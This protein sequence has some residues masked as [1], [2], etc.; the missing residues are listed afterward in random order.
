MAAFSEEV[1]QINGFNM[2]YKQIIWDFNGTILDDVSITLEATNLLLDRHGKRRLADVDEYRAH[3]GF[4]VIDYYVSI[5]LEREKF[6]QYADEWIAL[7]E[8]RESRA[9]LYAGCIELLDYFKKCGCAQYLL[10]ATER[11]MLRRQLAPLG[12]DEYFDSF[13]GQDDTRAHGKLAAALEWSKKVKLDGALF[14]GDSIHDAEVA[15]ALGVDCVLLA[16][17]HQSRA[18]LEET[19]CRVF[20]SLEVLHS[21]A[22]EGTL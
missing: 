17:G 11:K 10:S 1:G 2:K 20:D 5:G 16:S 18:R 7:Y 19:G 9:E 21:A 15:N 13:V 4:P 8:E 14:I 3:F 22:L 12:I 6:E